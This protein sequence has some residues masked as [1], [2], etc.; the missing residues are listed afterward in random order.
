VDVNVAPGGNITI[1]LQAE[2]LTCCCDDYDFITITITAVNDESCA[3]VTYE[4]SGPPAGGCTFEFTV[5]A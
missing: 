3:G 4:V 2:D 1:N 5:G